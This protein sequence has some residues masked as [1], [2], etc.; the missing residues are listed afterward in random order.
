MINLNGNITDQTSIDFFNRGLFYGDSVFE[1]LRCHLGTPLFYEAHYFRLMS[2]MRILRMEI[3]ADFTPEYLE[4]EITR[5]LEANK[6]QDKVA[7]LRIT[8]W[9]G[10]GGFYTPTAKNVEFA[11]HAEPLNESR[12]VLEDRFRESELFKDHY[13]TPGLLG[14]VKHNNRAV[15]VLAGIYARE[16]DY[17]DMI[18]LNEKK[19]LAE[20]ISGNIFLR[21][22]NKI[23]TPAK[24]DGCLDGIMRGQVMDQIKRMIDLEVEER[25]ITPFEIQ[26][27]DEVFTTNVIK[28]L[29]SIHK[30][31]KKEFST[32]VAEK[33]TQRLNDLLF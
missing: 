19:M 4:N 18:L 7:R 9:R 29:T 11:M 10:F 2:S 23:S 17:A 33:I 14:T 16:N 24:T 22:G 1:T 26:R 12:Y 28:G 21:H 27:A 20:A 25:T 6:L 13:V 3:P 8:V 31:R 32:E 30:Y 15:N 5:T